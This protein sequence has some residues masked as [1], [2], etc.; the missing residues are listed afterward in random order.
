MFESTLA[1][2]ANA[3]EHSGFDRQGRSRTLS[4]AL[5]SVAFYG[6]LFAAVIGL[7]QTAPAL[8][9]KTVDVLF[10]EVPPPP[11][12]APAATAVQPAVK[13]PTPG[14]TAARVAAVTP[15]LREST[16]RLQEATP[17][18]ATPAPH[19]AESQVAGGGDG[20]AGPQHAVPIG[21]EPMNLPED[22]T[23]PKASADNVA[24]TYPETA[25][26]LGQEGMVVLK[27]VV[28]ENGRVASVVVMKGEEPFASAAKAAVLQW[29][30]SPALIAGVPSAVYRIV[31][32]PFKIR[33]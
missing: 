8:V 33:S 18:E 21:R 25:R 30:Y 29:T 6:V 28:D 32:V 2:T 17:T 11:P 12:P 15:Q 19:A 14:P 13:K 26:S 5:L 4:T 31:K 1:A 27:I 23:P 3:T 9:E 20:S 10:R 24:P 16:E 22:A 7:S